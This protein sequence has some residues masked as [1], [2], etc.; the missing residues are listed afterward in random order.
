MRLAA[1]FPK[2]ETNEIYIVYTDTLERNS[3]ILLCFDTNKGELSLQEVSRYLD[4]KERS[5]KNRYQREF[6]NFSEICEIIDK[7]SNESV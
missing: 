4:G 5:N 1:C 2:E 6:K 7:D 3:S